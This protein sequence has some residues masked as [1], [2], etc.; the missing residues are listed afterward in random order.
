MHSKNHDLQT[1]STLDKFYC[2]R[3]LTSLIAFWILG[4]PQVTTNP[5]DWTL[6]RRLSR[7]WFD[8]FSSTLFVYDS[9][10]CSNFSK[11]T[12]SCYKNPS[13]ACRLASSMFLI[14]RSN[15]TFTRNNCFDSVKYEK[16]QKN[17]NRFF[18]SFL[19]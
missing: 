15:P 14:C 2:L 16:R 18:S 10:R 11:L 5:D 12:L 13:K 1:K 19:K 4:H 3:D 9:L 7:K 8:L 6:L 17:Q